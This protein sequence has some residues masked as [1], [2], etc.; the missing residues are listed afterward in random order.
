M[1]AQPENP[2]IKTVSDRNAEPEPPLVRQ[3]ARTVAAMIIRKKLRRRF[4]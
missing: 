1:T 2:T 4:R 3:M